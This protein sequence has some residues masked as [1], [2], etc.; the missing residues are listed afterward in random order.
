MNLD[1][2][3]RR[4]LVTGS[5]QGIGLATATAF[6]REGA[7]V[8]VNGRS[9]ERLEEARG[10]VLDAVPGARVECVAADLSITDGCNHMITYV[11]ELD[12]LI[13]NLGIFEP[14]DFFDIG[15]EDWDRLFETN[16]MSGVRLCRHYLRGMLGRDWGRIVFVS[17][18]SAV[19]I[20]VEM[21]H[22]GVTKT[23]Q[24]AL[25][26]GLAEMTRGT[27]VTVNSVLAGPTRSEGVERFVMDLAAKEGRSFE[28]VE[29][30]FFQNARPGSLLQ[31]FAHVDEVARVI[32]FVASQGAG[33]V[34]GA[35]IRAEGGVIQACL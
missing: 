11:P 4:V 19:Q 21:I 8:F 35:P 16:V 29:R 13:N 9:M 26:R 12:I 20:P 14:I 10:K 5:S 24:V 31:R 23:A 18:E 6:A 34:N 1:L 3:G 32:V 33:V 28:E 15:D 30:D 2:K 7:Q 22:Y 27:S 17:S 25:A